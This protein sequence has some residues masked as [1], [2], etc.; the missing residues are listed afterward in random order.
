[1]KQDLQ[2]APRFNRPQER[3]R[4]RQVPIRPVLSQD[5][6]SYAKHVNVQVRVCACQLRLPFFLCHEALLQIIQGNGIEWCP[7]T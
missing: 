3:P 5:L 2:D 7:H 1:M 4:H 6:V